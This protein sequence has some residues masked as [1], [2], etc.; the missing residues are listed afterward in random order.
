MMLKINYTTLYYLY[1]CEFLKKDKESIHNMNMEGK[2]NLN[3]MENH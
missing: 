2:Y 1:S 3:I